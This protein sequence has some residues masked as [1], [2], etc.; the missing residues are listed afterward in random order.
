MPPF[1]A[2]GRG[3]LSGPWTSS[4]WAP[5]TTPRRGSASA[6]STPR[7][8]PAAAGRTL[9]VEHPPVFTCGKRTDAARASARPGGRRGDRRR[10]R[11]Q[12]HL[13]RPRPAG[14][15]PDRATARPRAGRRLRAPGRGG[16][17]PGLRR[18]RRTRPRGC[19]AAAGCGCA[20]T[21]AVPSARSARS[22]SGS[23]AASPCT[24]SRSTAT[25]TSAGTTG[26]CRAGSPTPAS[27]RSAPSSVATS[28][29]PRRPRSCVRHLDDLLGLGA[30]RRHARLRGPPRAGPPAAGH[31]PRAAH[32]KPHLNPDLIPA[33]ARADLRHSVA[34]F[35]DA[36]VSDIADGRNRVDER[37]GSG[38]RGHRPAQETHGRRPGPPAV[39]GLDLAVDAGRVHGLLGPEGSGKTTT[40]RLLLGL[41][42]ADAGEIRLLG[43]SVPASW[44]RWSRGSAP[45]SGA[46]GSPPR[47]AVAATS[48]CS[49]RAAACRA[50][51]SRSARPGRAR[52]AATDQ[53]AALLTPH[54]AAAR[55]GR[56]PA[57][58]SRP[59]AARRAHQRARPERRPRGVATLVRELAG[60]GVSVLIGSARA[61]RGAAAVR[62]GDGPRA[63]PGARHRP[64]GRP[65][66]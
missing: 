23:A 37:A 13:P 35:T 1:D 17:D 33:D 12:D 62:H 61:G 18:P 64:R 44:P 54:A 15:L 38:D 8:W 5:S 51:A 10:P 20:P 9:L 19:P 42:R 60:E 32:L 31:G 14:R 34:W 4:I 56:G 48:R 63:R 16:P 43:R 47:S 28:P 30:V 29:S 6:R 46:R 39:D 41:A 53:G 55:P 25:S 22:G 49:A 3:V 36:G 7:S 40:L 21:R 2:P 65:G 66:R 50:P 24:A 45:W 58:G 52:G 26:S 11:R 57:A 59:A 27:P